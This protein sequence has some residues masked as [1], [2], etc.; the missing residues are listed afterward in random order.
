MKK[1]TTRWISAGVI[2]LPREDGRPQQ[3][4]YIFRGYRN[5]NRRFE[6]VDG[7]YALPVGGAT[8]FPVDRDE[9]R[10]GET[11]PVRMRV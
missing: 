5:S 6:R 7:G 8:L 11:G 1:I 9:L 2:L 3:P 10:V 4:P